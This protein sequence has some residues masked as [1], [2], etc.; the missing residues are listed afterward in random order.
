MN[1]HR[2]TRAK[3][4]W[5]V[6][7][8]A[9]L[10]ATVLAA[11]M[12]TGAATLAQGP[13]EGSWSRGFDGAEAT[14]GLAT[15]SDTRV[16]GSALKLAEAA[17]YDLGDAVPG[18][19]AVYAMVPVGNDV[20]SGT[21]DK[22]HLVYFDASEL[23][24]E[25]RDGPSHYGVSN[26][27][28]QAVPATET[29][30]TALAYD[31]ARYVYGGTYPNGHL[32]SFDTTSPGKTCHDNG[33]P[34]P[35][36]GP[37]TS[38]AYAGGLLYIG[39]QAGHTFTYS[40]GEGG[41]F[42]DIGQPSGSSPVKAMA[43]AD[44]TLYAATADGKLSKYSGGAF[45]DLGTPAAVQID[46]LVTSGTDLYIGYDDGTVRSYDTSGPGPFTLLC[47]LPG[48]T[49]VSALAV[50]AGVSYFYA[51]A[52][53]GHVYLYDGSVHDE[54]MP[55]NSSGAPVNT[56]AVADD[57]VMYGGTGSE[58]AGSTGRLFRFAAGVFEDFDRPTAANND[59]LKSVAFAIKTLYL[60]R[61]DRLY[62]FT[63][64]GQFKDYQSPD[65][66]VAINDIDAKMGAVFLGLQNGHLYSYNSSGHQDAFYDEGVPTSP[67]PVT[68]VVV[69]TYGDNNSN[70]AIYVGLEDG[71]L[72]DG[73]AM[74]GLPL[75]TLPG[76]TPS[77]K[78]MCYKDSGT[79]APGGLYIAGGDGHLYFWNGSLPLTDVGDN[80]DG[81][82]ANAVAVYDSKVYTGREN[83]KIYSWD[84]SSFT[85]LGTAASAIESMATGSRGVFCGTTGGHLY[86][87]D[88]PGSLYDEGSVPYGGSVLAVC[89]V[90]T[91]VWAGSAQGYLSS[92]DDANLGDFGQQVKK[93][94]MV[95]C[96]TYDPVRHVFYAGTYY[97]AHFLVID[98]ATNRITDLGRP[99][100]GERALLDVIVTREG[101]V[102]GST[103]G[104][105]DEK[106]NRDGG[107][108]YTYAPD[109]A[110]PARG[111]FTDRGRA[112]APDNNWWIS[113]LV[114]GPESGNLIYAATSN[115]AYDGVTYKEG[116][117]F[118][119]D[120]TT[121]AA[122]DLGVPVAGEGTNT[123]VR[124]GDYI[125]GA[126][127]HP[128]LDYISHVYRYDTNNPGSGNFT[129]LGDVPPVGLYSGNKYVNRLFVSGGRVYGSQNNGNTFWFDPDVAPAGWNPTS[130]GKPVSRSTSVYPLAGGEDGAILC[131]ST[132]GTDLHPFS[133]NLASYDPVLNQFRD[134]DVTSVTEAQHQDKVASIAVG[135][136]A[137]GGV[138]F[139]GTRGMLIGSTDYYA[140]R[141]FR[142]DPYRVVAPPPEA[143]A[144]S[145]VIDPS[146]IE[147][148]AIPDASDAIEAVCPAP[149]QAN[150][151]YV[152]TAG[153]DGHGYI[154]LY[155]VMTEQF[156]P[157]SR[158]DSGEQRVLSMCA[159]PDG[160]VYVGT[161]TDGGDV[162][163]KRFTPGGSLQDCGAATG[164][165][166]LRA[167]TAGPDGK[168]YFGSGESPSDSPALFKCDPA[169]ATVVPIATTLTTGNRIDSLV[170]SGS[171]V[172]GV[173]GSPPGG[174]SSVEFF[175]YDP[176]SG[177][178]HNMGTRPE[179]TGEWT[180]GGLVAAPD[181][182]LYFA[183]GLAGKL[184]RYD[185]VAD[186]FTAV[187]EWLPSDPAEVTALAATGSNAS[188]VMLYGCAGSTGRLFKFNPQ[189]AVFTDLGP[190]TVHDTG[191]R[192]ATTDAL[193]NP[194]FGTSGDTK[195]IRYDV[196]RAF[197]W[198]QL[199]FDKTV[200]PPSTEAHMDICNE[201]GAV[202]QSD[203]TSPADI[204]GTAPVRLQA[205]LKTTDPAE[206]PAFTSWEVTW[207][208]KASVDT[209]AYPYQN[210]PG[211]GA[212]P[213][214][215]LWIWG[216]DFGA[217]AGS[218]TIGGHPVPPESV[219]W[220]PN[221]IQVTVPGGAEPG[222]TLVVAPAV[223]EAEPSDAT[224]VNIL[225]V[226]H[227]VSASPSSARL[228]DVVEV[229]G[230]GFL[231]SRG[232]GDGVLFNGLSATE[233]TQWSDTVI[234]AKVPPLAATGS[235]SV[236]VNQHVSTAIHFT[237]IGGGGPT[238]TITAPTE[239]ANVTGN[240]AVRATVQ[241]E[242]GTTPVE[243]W[244]DGVKK[245]SDPAAPYTFTWNADSVTDGA[246]TLTVK[247]TDG[248]DRQG[249]KSVT[250][251]VDHTVPSRSQTWYFAEGCTDY[252]FET[253]VLI[254][255]PS[256]EVAQARVTFMDDK[257]ATFV[258]S[259]ALAPNS[260]TTVN[261]ADV[262]PG[263]NVSV[264]VD[265]DKQVV[266]ERSMYWGNRVEGHSTIGTTS[267]SK[268]WYFAEGSTD[269]GFETFVLLGNP[270]GSKV[271][272]TVHYLFPDGTSAAREHDIAPH[273][274]VTV[275]AASD[276]GARD[277]SVKI[278]AGDPGI[279][280]ERS[281]YHGN[282][283]CGTGT[284]GAKQP[285]LTWFLSEGST[286]WGFETWLLIQR[287]GAGDARVT[288]SYRKASGETVERVYTVKGNSR[289]TVDLSREVG[290]ADVS[291][292]VTSNVG[293]VCERSMYWNGRTAGHSTI[294]S[295]GPG[296]TWY[297]AEG[298]SDYGFETWVLLDNPSGAT[299]NAT[300]TFM[301]EDGTTVPAVIGL[302]P[303]S[304][305]SV[306]AATY[307]GAASFST[308]VSAATPIMVERSVY[309]NN[310]SGGTGSIGA[311]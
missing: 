282:R 262:A 38:M 197:Q 85:A 298:C 265:A 68:S 176:S 44:G 255:N 144:L 224:A 20:Y 254:G 201:A 301:K 297:L 229:H 4:I 43:E 107:H 36:M 30:V 101:T 244:V 195:L 81:S 231:A 180:A 160:K 207:K 155:D 223:G 237:V 72:M 184:I 116:R 309:W 241:R 39:T 93:Q 277:F 150:R 296:R 66:G 211:G 158:L 172:Y 222:D 56:L 163:V 235:L 148:Q 77:I 288:A 114:E 194:Y 109:P 257:G 294:G 275:N 115:S 153:A 236:T 213:G 105:T 82:A 19:S 216:G 23:Y 25:G 251:Y 311:R 112:P 146:M 202:L 283:R 164:Y 57:N 308:K 261:A 270:G 198:D 230:S 35:A 65:P 108:V 37:V 290:T 132:G 181:G 190:L 304:R 31:G 272:A 33:V 285:S 243:L 40:G 130:L 8:A 162:K 193:G 32:F 154:Y 84:G 51:G 287:P 203:V 88:D 94:V 171:K 145:T 210:P 200:P 90:G 225:A 167:A 189:G 27:K 98:P 168:V 113:G 234:K 124:S 52:A 49:A 1:N 143:S 259:F 258:R 61:G 249:S 159:G 263:A 196:N 206:T 278:D 69:H 2:K 42:T 273:S 41:T 279:V 55:A 242:G 256:S 179:Y 71:R 187:H 28:G 253:W 64:P 104:G 16:S 131:G 151:L 166:S 46:S 14:R 80:A 70:T 295:P 60:A 271:K 161:G 250:V 6:L 281:M 15:Q 17:P 185:P 228:G 24:Q 34:A 76:A 110:D 232:S 137:V 12:V 208:K 134:L 280:A 306:N 293:V 170:T 140:A 78:D 86:S 18:E 252:G 3:G 50:R 73:T 126:T 7:V 95:W 218:V 74:T 149:G 268:T 11:S 307:V 102:V 291:T 303:H 45:S 67:S 299:V 120:K 266:C 9:A 205:R 53:D 226:P 169:T 156:F 136:G 122:T 157:G 5:A 129:A 239:G 119:L 92:H 125:T 87:Q 29:R 165:A 212:Y 240:V 48:G 204:V 58:A 267:L 245:A 54:G 142:V 111:E 305:M 310:R 22:G 63:A 97:N 264:K 173:A 121:W 260:R 147:L 96:M 89:H 183:T 103:Y 152:G 219:S 247:A 292:Q 26:S 10:A 186:S 209:L 220:H 274:R 75:A 276:V 269:Y 175:S 284:I 300:L 118:T 83:G 182:K 59:D 127:W 227:V 174:T 192:A 246:H 217:S 215:S 135:T 106:H 99:I 188:N 191:V 117:F 47:T 177:Q 62:S 79:G 286:D 302:K 21:G 123:L 289:Y 248:Y 91:S 238:V 13:A 199:T 133:G 233:Y 221:A 100:A 138:T 128:A 178:F 214:D 141:I 139:C